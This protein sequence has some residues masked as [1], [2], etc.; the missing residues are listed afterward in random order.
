MYTKTKSVY[1][2]RVGKYV[3]RHLPS[4]ERPTLVE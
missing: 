1:N 3:L 2:H 4:P